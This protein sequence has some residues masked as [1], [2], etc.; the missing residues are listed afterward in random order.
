M[1]LAYAADKA[2]TTNHNRPASHGALI[3]AAITLT[4]TALGAGPGNPA[5]ASVDSN[6][7]RDTGTRTAAPVAA[8]GPGGQWAFFAGTVL[9]VLNDSWVDPHHSGQGW[10]QTI[11]HWPP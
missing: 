1:R 10:G 9:Q 11:E 3:G 7:G 8:A 4:S 5:I 6:L 2:M